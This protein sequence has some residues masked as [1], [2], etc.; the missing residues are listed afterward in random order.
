M[1]RIRVIVKK[2]VKRL[3]TLLWYINPHREKFISCSLK[4]PDIFSELKQY[5]YNRYYN[6][7]Y[8]TGHYKKE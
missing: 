4:L 7:F 5:Q 6:N 3:V 8:H 1:H 2:F